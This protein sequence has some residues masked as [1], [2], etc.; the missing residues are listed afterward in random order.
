MSDL[1]RL[2]GRLS[3][4][5]GEVAGHRNSGDGTVPGYTADALT[6]AAYALLGHLDHLTCDECGTTGPDVK[7]HGNAQSLGGVMDMCH[8]WKA[9]E[10]RR[11]LIIAAGRCAACG[12]TTGDDLTVRDDR[13]VCRAP[14]ACQTR[15]ATAKEAANA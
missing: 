7:R 12:R 11:A 3:A 9:C 8:D 13:V 4:A 10:D 15:S 14:F 1:R 2:I 5:A 6:D